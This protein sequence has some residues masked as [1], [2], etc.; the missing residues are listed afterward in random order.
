MRSIDAAV[1]E[2]VG[3][4]NR[5]RARH[6][7]DTA[8]GDGRLTIHWTVPGRAPRITTI[9][10][11][12][13]PQQVSARDDDGMRAVHKNFSKSSNFRLMWKSCFSRGTLPR[14][15]DGSRFT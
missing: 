8:D 2:A 10:A 3:E 5:V 1:R 15:H 4:L 12:T 11:G 14:C 9:D 6:Y 7:V 13:S